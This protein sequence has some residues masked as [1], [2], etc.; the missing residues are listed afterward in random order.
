MII[1]PKLINLSRKI[2]FQEI[3]LNDLEKISS[4]KTLQMQLRL[5]KIPKWPLLN[6][7]T[8]KQVFA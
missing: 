7:L 6:R 3:S 2:N 1:A 8:E 5:V 4:L